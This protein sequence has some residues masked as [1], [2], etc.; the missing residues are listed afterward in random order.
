MKLGI[1]DQSQLSIV[2]PHYEERGVY[3][4]YCS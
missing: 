3:D 2:T 1:M 4:I